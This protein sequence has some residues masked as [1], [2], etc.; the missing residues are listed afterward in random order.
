MKTERSGRVRAGLGL[1]GAALAVVVLGLGVV[2]IVAFAGSGG[3]E[4][5]PVG[6]DLG[7]ARVRS[8]AITTLANG[9]LEAKNQLEIRN[10]VESRTAIVEI[11]PEGT[12]VRRGEVL[13]RLADESLRNRIAEEELAV[14]QARTELENAQAAEMIQ[15]SEN[16]SLLRAAE[17][18][19]AIAELTYSQWEQGD[20]V[21]QR[22]ELKLALERA[23]KNHERLRSKYEN[24]KRLYEKNFLSKDELD[25]DEI[26]FIEAQSTLLTATLD[27]DVYDDFQYHKDAE[28]R[29]REVEEAAA[30]LERV[31]QE[32]AI[33]L[34]SRQTQTENRQR[35][36]A[37]RESKLAELRAQLEYC[38]IVA[39]RDG[40]VVYGSSVQ[41]DNRRWMNDGG[42]TVGT[43]VGFNDL[44]IA[45]PDTSEMTASVKVHE[46]LAGRVRPGQ[47][48]SVKVDAIDTV[49]PGLVSSIG[50][51]AETG[52]WRDPNKREYTVKVDLNPDAARGADLKPTLRCEARIELGRVTDALTV[53]VQAVFNDGP[54]RFVLRPAAGGRYARVPVLVGRTSDTEAEVLR[55]L[56]EGD[57]V[58]LRNPQAGEVEN[59]TAWDPATLAAGGYVLNEQGKP[60]L[61]PEAMRDLMRRPGALP[62][63]GDEGGAE[64]SSGAAEGAAVGAS[65][66]GGAAAGEGRRRGGAGRGAGA[67]GS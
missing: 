21:K 26:A 58:L 3:G 64:G 37:L 5:G 29:R 44:L 8:F 19:K 20:V 10:R 25:R 49:I 40:L 61:D 6:L 62:P 27:K 51:M 67:G 11:I 38:T 32:N 12:T 48:V 45:L 13:M 43:E 54:V 28:Q 14:L 1:W 36:L 31:R 57:R 33:N 59:P 63:A 24:S 39:P 30:E 35:Q 52:G 7:T 23:E 53:P 22:Q 41:S 2:G 4:E 18:K 60:E 66:G 55:G 15:I 42:M 50:V 46:S 47:A 17:S 65:T 56:A 9:E 34:R 16:D